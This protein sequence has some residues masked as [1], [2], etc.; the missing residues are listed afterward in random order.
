MGCS[1]LSAGFTSWTH[2]D[3]YNGGKIIRKSSTTGPQFELLWADLGAGRI[4][5][6]ICIPGLHRIRFNLDFYEEYRDGFL[7]MTGAAA[8]EF[9]HALGL[10]H[11][12]YDPLDVDGK[13]RVGSWWHDNFY[14][15]PTMSTCGTM[16][17]WTGKESIGRDEYA[18][19]DFID[20]T[21]T[22]GER[23][24]R[25]TLSN[26]SFEGYFN[27]W[28]SSGN[29]T[30]LKIVTGAAAVGDRYASFRAGSGSQWDPDASIWN[31]V[32]Y[33][34]LDDN[35]ADAVPEFYLRMYHKMASSNHVGFA[36]YDLRMRY[37]NYANTA[38]ND[39]GYP[40]DRT[41]GLYEDLEVVESWGL[42]VSHTGACGSDSTAWTACMSPAWSPPSP[43]ADAWDVEATILSSLFTGPG[44]LAP[45]QVHVDNATIFVYDTQCLTCG[46]Q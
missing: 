11:T 43:V 17:S 38:F 13:T 10:N 6:T 32:R 12:Q 31:R 44:T 33:I 23:L 28:L 42:F 3:S 8:H 16:Q 40:R 46:N 18:G 27:H 22:I 5:E 39:C 24:I 41:T 19:A 9:G 1:R 29:A 14:A 4:A 30:D 26:P 34:P 21:R 7:S 25:S 2:P 45:A 35:V 36:R 37:I 20:Q 15:I